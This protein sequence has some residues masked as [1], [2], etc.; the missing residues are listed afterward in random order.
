MK[1]KKWRALDHCDLNSKEEASD[2]DSMAKQKVANHQLSSEWIIVKDSEMIDIQTTDTQA[3][4]SIQLAVQAAIVAVISIAVGDTNQ[5]EA[6]S[7]E[8]KQYIYTKQA[9]KQKLVIH[10]SKNVQ[11]TTT[12]TDI[13]VNIEALLQILVA[14]L[15]KLD[16]L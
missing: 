5:A 16:I 6:I 13:V 9:N 4:V 7:Q 15:V 1:E 14:I 11:V 3:A 8:L 10:N 2:V 12:D